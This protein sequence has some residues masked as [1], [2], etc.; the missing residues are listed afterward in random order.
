MQWVD[1]RI[2]ENTKRLA[3]FARASRPPAPREA[4]KQQREIQARQGAI[5]AAAELESER[6][7]QFVSIC[8]D[9]RRSW[10]GENIKGAIEGEA[11]R[12]NGAWN[13]STVARL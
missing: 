5:E 11:T 10:V 1:R 2:R 12:N 4:C 3:G 7:Q 6:C 13:Q 8:S 9:S